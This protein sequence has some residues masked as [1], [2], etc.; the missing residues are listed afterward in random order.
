MATRHPRCD[1]ALSVA[2]SQAAPIPPIPTSTRH[3]ETYT[4]SDERKF[5]IASLRIDPN[6]GAV[7]TQRILTTV[8]IRKPLKTEFV[9]THPVPEIHPCGWPSEISMAD[10]DNLPLPSTTPTSRSGPPQ[11]SLGRSRR[12]NTFGAVALRV[13]ANGFVVMPVRGKAAFM[14]NYNALYKKPPSLGTVRRWVEKHG[15]LNTGLCLGGVVAIDIDIDDLRLADEV[16]RLVISHLGKSTFVRFGRQPRCALL[17]R[18]DRR[19][20]EHLLRGWSVGSGETGY[21]ELLGPGKQIVIYGTHPNTLLPYE[22]PWS[23]PLSADVKKVPWTTI[24]AL[25]ELKVTLKKRLK[26]AAADKS[27]A[28]VSELQTQWSLDYL[29]VVGERDK[30]LFWYALKKAAEY[31]DFHDLEKDVL[32]K[33]AKFPTPLL[34]AQTR[35]KAKSAWKYKVE[36]RLWPSGTKA[37]VV[38]PVS[39]ETYANLARRLS[40]HAIKLYTILVATR[41]TRK[42]FTIPQQATANHLGMGKPTIVKAIKELI[43][44]GLIEDYDIRRKHALLHHPAKQYRFVTPPSSSVVGASMSLYYG[45]VAFP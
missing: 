35:E 7:P 45:L 14:R 31:D 21:V 34:E 11:K 17:Y 24:E 10:P 40:P 13:Q 33:N 28:E 38:L 2:F 42:L 16:Q 25:D 19:M 20:A 43:K 22:W 26:P 30:F 8:A 23:S 4:M 36:G 15:D 18:I 3:A 39:R 1:A 44:M 5:D 6:A 12:A 37:P 29:P 41:D 9:R 32:D 27:S